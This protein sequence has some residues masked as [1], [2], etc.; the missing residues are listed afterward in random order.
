[1]VSL[2]G[3][4]GEDGWE[5]YHESDGG[6][7]IQTQDSQLLLPVLLFSE[8]GNKPLARKEKQG[9]KKGRSIRPGEETRTNRLVAKY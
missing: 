2:V 5:V 9:R 6:D 4:F 7:L 3:W 1:M 8:R